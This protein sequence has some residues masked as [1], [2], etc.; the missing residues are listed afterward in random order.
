MLNYL[1]TFLHQL[2]ASS[3][4]GM[5]TQCPHPQRVQVLTALCAPLLHHQGHVDGCTIMGC[6]LKIF[7]YAPNFEPMMIFVHISSKLT[8]YL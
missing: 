6:K 4:N 1:Q 5:V 3:R 2:T 8:L 7:H